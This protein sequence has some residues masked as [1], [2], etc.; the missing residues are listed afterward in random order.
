MFFALSK[1]LG[2]I[3]LPTN[4][5]IELGIVGLFLLCTRF[6][7]VGRKLLV[8]SVSG[9]ALLGYSPLGRSLILPL[10]DRFPAWD[11]S[12]GQPDGIIVLGGIA[13][14]FSAA[15]G[16]PL[17]NSGIDR[18]IAAAELGHRYP[19]ARIVFS[20]GN[21]NLLASEATEAE[22]G[23]SVLES[24]GLQRERLTYEGRS[25][26]TAENA[27]FTMEVVH[28]KPGERWLLVTSAFHMPRAVGAFRKV[29]FPVEP[30]PVDWRTRGRQD[31]FR[32]SP[33][34]IGG[35][36]N[37]DTGIREWAGLLIYWLMGETSEIFPGPNAG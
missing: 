7:S 15:R 4:I 31:L 10:E 5:F 28:P 26:N 9:L 3:F 25:R 11:A 8:I 27:K 13:V 36:V 17:F 18:V 29:G 37:F 16:V 1:T 24:L 2:V 23:I 30:Y 35:V 33:Y 19:E 22:F 32:F 21:P 6:A 34:F 12:R 14:E 20:G